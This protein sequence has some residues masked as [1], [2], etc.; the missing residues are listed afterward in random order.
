MTKEQKE[1]M[2]ECVAYGVANKT[3]DSDEIV[4]AVYRNRLALLNEITEHKDE[5]IP[6]LK[7]L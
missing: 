2:N 5:V 6:L 4:K 3:T 1:F 7:Q